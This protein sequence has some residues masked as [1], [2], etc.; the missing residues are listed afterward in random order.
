MLNSQDDLF[1]CVSFIPWQNVKSSRPIALMLCLFVLREK[2]Q[3]ARHKK[4]GCAAGVMSVET[5]GCTLPRIR[6]WEPHSFCYDIPRPKQNDGFTDTVPCFIN[7][8]IHSTLGEV[9]T[10]YPH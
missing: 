7:K 8:C 5:G 2:Y 10:F 9:I 1:V 6:G 4:L 3:I